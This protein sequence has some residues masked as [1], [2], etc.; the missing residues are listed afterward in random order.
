[1]RDTRTFP[2]EPES[3][4]AARRFATSVLRGA[5]AHTLEAVEL[6]VS[7]LATNCIRH[8]NSEFDL[9]IIR[10]GSDIRVEAT[11]W[12]GG[13]P[14]MR[15]PKPTDASGR[16]LKIVDTLSARWGVAPRASAG[17]TVWFMISDAGA[18][19]GEPSRA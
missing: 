17:K 9:T 3:V 7:E 8:T 13:T 19:A 4:P 5:S 18:P 6:M 16:G 12:A 11:D 1:M 14:A 15:S 2:H 10:N